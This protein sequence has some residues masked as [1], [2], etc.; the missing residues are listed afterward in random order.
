MVNLRLSGVFFF[1]QSFEIKQTSVIK[2]I[3]NL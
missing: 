1:N 3:V 2:K